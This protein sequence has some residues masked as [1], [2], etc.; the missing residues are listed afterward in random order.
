MSVSQFCQSFQIQPV[1][2]RISALVVTEIQNSQSCKVYLLPLAPKK[3]DMVCFL[4][5]DL[6]MKE[7]KLRINYHQLHFPA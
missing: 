1:F 7:N 2:C 6:L 3:G 4:Y 5:Q